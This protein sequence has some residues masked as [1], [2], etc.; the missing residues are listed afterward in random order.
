VNLFSVPDATGKDP[1]RRIQEAIRLVF[2]KVAELGSV[3]QALL[4]FHEHE[5][6]LPARRSNGEVTW[7]RPRYATLH[8][9][10][11]NPIYGGAYAYGKTGAVTQ[12]S[13]SAVRTKSRRKPRK[14]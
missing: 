8:R 6:D 14:E 11:T 3:R 13:G 7:R 2:D 12:Y 1:D 5:L 4:W 9:M 10:V